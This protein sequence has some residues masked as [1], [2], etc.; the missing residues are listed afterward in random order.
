MK[1]YKILSSHLGMYTIYNENTKTSLSDIEVCNLL[2]DLSN[3]NK[4]FKRAVKDV[5]QRKYE[6]NNRK[7]VFKS[8]A[9]ELGLE[10]DL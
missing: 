7:M 5:L 4:E 10:L 9:E 2:N 1:Q 3:E 6:A 8:I